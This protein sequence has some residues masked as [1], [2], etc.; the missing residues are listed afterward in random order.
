V[1]THAGTLHCFI[2]WFSFIVVMCHSPSVTSQQPAANRASLHDIYCQLLGRILEL[3][4]A[5]NF[6]QICDVSQE[7][8]L[9]GFC[10]QANFRGVHLFHY[11]EQQ[12]LIMPT[13]LGYL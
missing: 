2:W 11:F 1:L 3:L 10:N 7:A 5:D 6:Y 12:N 4:T 13:N 8:Q 9:A